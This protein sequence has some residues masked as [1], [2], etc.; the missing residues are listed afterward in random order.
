MASESSEIP[1]NMRRLY[2]R[3]ERWRSAHTGPLPIPER[4]WT[5]AAELAREHRVFP[6]AKSLHLEYGK[7]KQ[8][9]TSFGQIK[10]CSLAGRTRRSQAQQRLFAVRQGTCPAETV[11]SYLRGLA[12]SDRSLLRQ[13]QELLALFR[14]YRPG[15]RGSTGFWAKTKTTARTRCCRSYCVSSSTESVPGSASPA[16]EFPW[17]SDPFRPFRL[18]YSTL[19]LERRKDS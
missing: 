7:L 1:H 18:A 8:L 2:R 15:S 5:A 17:G 13:L 6:T 19:A 16:P 11:E 10:S 14:A 3:F 9:A 4:L 12:D